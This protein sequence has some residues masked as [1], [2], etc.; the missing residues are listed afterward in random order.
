MTTPQPIYAIGDVHG[1]LSKLQDAHALIEAD[2]AAH[3]TPDTGVVHIGDLCDRGPDTKGVID[4]M[5]NGVRAGRPWVV[6]KGNHDR[7][8]ARYL[9]ADPWHDPRLWPGLS[10]QHPRLGGLATLA[11]YGVDTDPERDPDDIHRDA[12]QA[13]GRD[14][15]R[16]LLSRPLYHRAGDLLFVHAGIRPGVALSDQDEID[17]L[18]IRED[19]LTDTTDHGPLVV[20]GHTMVDRVELHPN[21]LNIDTGAG[22]GDDLSAVVIEGRRVWRLTPQ[23]RQQVAPLA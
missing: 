18:W 17:L 15:P 23:G 21:R 3:T 12:R 1:H 6:L 16:F 7:M 13:V 22:R 19:F 9:E 14:H 11:S 20:H 2:R 8:F 10:W 4:F 5:L